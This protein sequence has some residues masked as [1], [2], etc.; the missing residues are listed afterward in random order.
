MNSPVI[1][2]F[3]GVITKVESNTNKLL[4]DD[5]TIICSTDTLEK[6]RVGAPSVINATLTNGKWLAYAITNQSKANLKTEENSQAKH[7]QTNTNAIKSPGNVTFSFNPPKKKHNNTTKTQ[8]ARTITAPKNQ[9]APAPKT[10][11]DMTKVQSSFKRPIFNMG[12]APNSDEATSQ[13]EA[14]E[15]K[16]QKEL[17]KKFPVA[18]PNQFEDISY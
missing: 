7:T 6:A 1:A 5:L 11:V 2:T 15:I 18:D 16:R 8:G 9:P 14:L 3:V 10:K 17:M 12:A 13:R 4:M